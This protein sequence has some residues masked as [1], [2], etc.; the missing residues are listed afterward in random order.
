MIGRRDGRLGELEVARRLVGLEHR[1][2]LDQLA[3]LLGAGLDVA[4]DRELV[5]DERVVD[6]ASRSGTG[7]RR[8]CGLL[9]RSTV[10]PVG[11]APGVYSSG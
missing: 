3:E 4:Q 8:A 9:S 6:H 1:E 10:A 7:W 2:L 11:R 5:L